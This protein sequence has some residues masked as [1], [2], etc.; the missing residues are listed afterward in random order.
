M[1]RLLIILIV[2][3][4]FVVSAQNEEENPITIGIN[5]G[6][7]N[8]INAYRLDPNLNGNNFSSDNPNY[9]IAL[10]FGIKLSEKYRMRLGV[11][12]VRMGYQADWT[13]TSLSTMLDRSEVKLHYSDVN[14]HVDYMLFN[15]S[16]FQIYISPFVNWEFN[17]SKEC[18][19]VKI[20]GTYNY[21]QI[22]GII[23]ENPD[24]VF[25]GGISA[26]LKYNLNNHFGLTL[27]PEYNIFFNKFVSDNDKLYQRTSINFGFEFRF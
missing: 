14:L 21:K 10:D 6:Y 17:V 2:L 7:D 3:L 11:K 20:D 16:K 23:N 9:N 24:N 18:K 19:N 25:G 5:A 8:N 22:Y 26:I 15:R 4:P 27:T 13:N 1:K 12:Y